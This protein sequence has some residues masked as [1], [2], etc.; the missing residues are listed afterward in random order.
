[1]PR[2]DLTQQHLLSSLLRRQNFQLSLFRRICQSPGKA[3]NLLRNLAPALSAHMLLLASKWK[4]LLLM[5]LL[6]SLRSTQSL[7]LPPFFPTVFEA[8]AQTAG[9]L[10]LQIMPS[11][12]TFYS[13]TTGLFSPQNM[14]QHCVIWHLPTDSG[15]S[16]CPKA[17]HS[18]EH[19]RQLVAQ[20][21][22]AW[23]LCL[24]AVRAG[25][26]PQALDPAGDCPWFMFP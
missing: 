26:F 12:V 2:G 10:I 24:T 20:W 4:R 21:P 22:T 5:F 18:R 9:S 17:I 8:S 14:S 13:S 15:V 16:L 6:S 25:T 11:A 3:T 19:A 1:M 23:L 7:S